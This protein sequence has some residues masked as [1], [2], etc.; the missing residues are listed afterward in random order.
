MKSIND[1][2]RGKAPSYVYSNFIDFILKKQQML[3]GIQVLDFPKSGW[4]ERVIL[5]LCWGNINR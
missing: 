5:Y 2:R 4:S 1:I 3:E